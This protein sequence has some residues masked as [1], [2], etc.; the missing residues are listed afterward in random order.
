M[1][2]NYPDNNMNMYS[3]NK[4]MYSDFDNTYNNPYNN[5]YANVNNMNAYPNNYNPSVIDVPPPNYNNII[6]NGYPA[7]VQVNSQYDTPM[8]AL[9][10]TNRIWTT[11]KFIFSKLTSKRSKTKIH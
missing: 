8:P 11:I 7:F 4:N 5:P 1:N 9:P 6:Q 3:T 2:R 10:A